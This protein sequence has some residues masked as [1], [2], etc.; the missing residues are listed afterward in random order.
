MSEHNHSLPLHN[1]SLLASQAHKK[2]FK[3]SEWFDWKHA[4]LSRCLHSFSDMAFDLECSKS[5]IPWWRT[6]MS[7]ALSIQGHPTLHLWFSQSQS[8]P[9]PG[10]TFVWHTILCSKFYSDG[11]LSSQIPGSGFS[12]QPAAVMTSQISKW[13]RDWALMTCSFQAWPPGYKPGLRD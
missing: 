6:S 5:Q 2:I 11:C 8:A 12:S 9:R 10:M 1:I 13:V 3:F 7:C 4:L